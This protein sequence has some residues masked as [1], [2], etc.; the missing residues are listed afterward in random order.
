MKKFAIAA[1]LLLCFTGVSQASVLN[2]NLGSGLQELQDESQSMFENLDGSVDGL[3]RPTFTAGDVIWG[4][5]SI[6]D[7]V[8]GQ[9]T[10]EANEQIV[11][12][13]AFEVGDVIL[14]GIFDV[15]G[16]TVAGFTIDDLLSDFTPMGAGVGDTTAFIVLSNDT[17]LDP[18]KDSP[19]EPGSSVLPT[20][21]DSFFNSTDWSYELTGG[22]A[23][24]TDDYSQ[25]FAG[26][27]ISTIGDQVGGFTIFDQAFTREFKDVDLTNPL[28]QVTTQHD[29]TLDLSTIRSDASGRWDFEDNA[30]FFVNSVPEPSSILS[31]GAL[32]G[33]G[34]FVAARRRRKQKQA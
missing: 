6:S 30:D 4:F 28:T 26:N 11:V 18:L 15:K 1:A 7:I 13:Y 24:G 5:A 33:A 8:P 25:F 19:S 17:G 21:F 27:G 3:G 20:E 23:A 32:M 2:A 34:L 29:I 10:L 16:S 12:A 31:F 22:I 14:P 9:G